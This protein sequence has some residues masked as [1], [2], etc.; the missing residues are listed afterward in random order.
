MVGIARGK[1]SR[2]L[3]SGDSGRALNARLVPHAEERL[4]V[5]QLAR[6]A[7]R[8]QALPDPLA[9]GLVGETRIADHQH[10]A[11]GLRANEADGAL[12]KLDDRLR[13]LVVDE[14]G[15]ARGAQH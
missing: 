10:D 3:P 12:L 9:V 1:R 4:D 2:A 11:I 5:L 6:P 8:R 14:W 7:H 13:A 15:T